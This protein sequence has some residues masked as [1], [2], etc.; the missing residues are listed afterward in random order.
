MDIFENIVNNSEINELF[1][2]NILNKEI[3]NIV[4]SSINIRVDSLKEYINL[5]KK[6][7]KIINEKKDFNNDELNLFFKSLITQQKLSVYDILLMQEIQEN[8]NEDIKKFNLINYYNSKK[9]KIK[10][11]LG[12]IINELYN[13][14]INTYINGFYCKLKIYYN[15]NNL[16]NKYFVND[17]KLLLPICSDGRFYSWGYVDRIS[18]IGNFNEYKELS[19]NSDCFKNDFKIFKIY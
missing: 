8:N 14:T 19:T 18:G 15:N 1:N 17:N 7:K 3:N 9:E 11:T 10:I 16:K 5:I 2:I 12:F 13:D 4:K 6:I